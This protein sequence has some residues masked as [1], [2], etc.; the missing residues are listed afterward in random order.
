M[1][2]SQLLLLADHVKLSLL[3]QQRAISLDLEPDSHDGEISKSLDSLREGLEKLEAQNPYA[4]SYHFHLEA[5]VDRPPLQLIPR[6]QPHPHPILRPLH[7]IPRH[8][9]IYT[10]K[11]EA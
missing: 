3:E 7:A 10:H 2:A 5:R 9:T 1:A 8:L 4:P 11:I 6:N